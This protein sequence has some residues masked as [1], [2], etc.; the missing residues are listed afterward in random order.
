[1]LAYIEGRR[2]RKTS[3]AQSSKANSNPREHE[4]GEDFGGGVTLDKAVLAHGEFGRF[5][6][7]GMSPR[8]R[9]S[10]RTS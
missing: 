2:G 8:C 5:L 10:G 4:L 1:M 7:L 6:P 9:C 3:Q